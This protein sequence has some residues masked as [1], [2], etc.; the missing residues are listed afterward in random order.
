MDFLGFNFKILAHN[1]N[2]WHNKRYSLYNTYKTEDPDVVLLSE[3]GVEEEANMKMFG[4]D[5]IHKNPTQERYDGAAIGIKRHIKY[6][7]RAKKRK[8]KKKTTPPP[9]SNSLNP[10]I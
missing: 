7:T 6:K 2:G 9:T 5:V 3:H 8:N 10:P 1:V 4:Y